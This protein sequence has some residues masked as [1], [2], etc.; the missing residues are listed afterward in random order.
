MM[1][2]FLA[3]AGTPQAL[4][5][6]VPELAPKRLLV[7]DTRPPLAIASCRAGTFP[8]AIALA[9]I[10]TAA[11][12]QLPVTAR[13]VQQPIAGDPDHDPS[14]RQHTGQRVVIASLSLQRDKR[15]AA[16]TRRSL[17]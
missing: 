4:P 15:L 8:P 9:M 12:P 1:R 14:R 13:T 3:L 2:H 17:R 10:A 11:D 16:I 7:T 6:G 5:G